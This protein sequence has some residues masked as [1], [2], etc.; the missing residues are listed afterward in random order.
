MLQQWRAK[1][2]KTILTVTKQT[3]KMR[4]RRYVVLYRDAAIY[5]EHSYDIKSHNLSAP[6]FIN[7]LRLQ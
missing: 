2:T 4:L 3:I 6:P 5:F 7:S 1:S